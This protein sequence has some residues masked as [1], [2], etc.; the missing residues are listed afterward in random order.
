[1]KE[2]QI[3]IDREKIRIFCEKWKIVEFSLFGSVLTNEFRPDSDVDVM[4]EFAPDARW[5]FRQWLE[6]ED[7][8]RRIL[9]RN[10][11]LVERE[12]IERSDNYIRRRS[13]L[14][15]SQRVYGY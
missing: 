11:D 4:V 2:P 8:L 7:E 14:Q 15:G 13:I 9:G 3:P 12:T 6:M 10:I 5:R 1:M